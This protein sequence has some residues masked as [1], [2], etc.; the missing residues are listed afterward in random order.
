MHFYSFL[1]SFV[2]LSVEMPVEQTNKLQQTN[3]QSTQISATIFTCWYW[4]MKLCHG[5]Y[6]IIFL[7]STSKR[8]QFTADMP[9][10]D[11]NLW[12]KSQ[13]MSICK[14]ISFN[15]CRQFALC[16]KN[17]LKIK[18]LSNIFN[19]SIFDLKVEIWIFSKIK[20]LVD[21]N[22]KNAQRINLQMCTENLEILV[23]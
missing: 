9:L 2:C 4:S 18:D 20:I 14:I 8:F 21:Q 23:D 3:K 19:E 16:Q 6:F 1:L 13:N 17:S 10:L 7:W 22:V 12:Q 15:I 11:H 5:W